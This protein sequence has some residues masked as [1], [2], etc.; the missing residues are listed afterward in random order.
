[1]NRREFLKLGSAAVVAAVVPSL[2]VDAEPTEWVLGPTMGIDDNSTSE[3]LEINHWADFD[4]A[5]RHANGFQIMAHWGDDVGKDLVKRLYAD[6]AKH[7]PPW[8]R[9]RVDI[10]GPVSVHYGRATNISWRYTPPGDRWQ[11]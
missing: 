7:I 10:Y 6:M 4:P 11:G 2:V 5:Q 3:L 8:Y 9:R 1:M